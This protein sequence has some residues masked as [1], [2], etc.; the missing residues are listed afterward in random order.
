MVDVPESRLPQDSAGVG[1][2][3]EHRCASLTDR[4]PHQPPELSHV[5]D[6]LQRVPAADEIGGEIPVRLRVEVLDEGD[7]LGRLAVR[8]LGDVGR[9]DADASVWPHLAEEQEE[10]ALPAPDLQDPL[11]VQI[12]SVDEPPREVLRERSEP[13]GEA[14]GFLVVP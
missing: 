6:M 11:A 9:V 14:L 2:L 1:H 5:W 8:S 10:L 3:E 4:A 13:G 12:E 7:A